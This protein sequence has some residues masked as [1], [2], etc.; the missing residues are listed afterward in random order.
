M[1]IDVLPFTKGL[2]T[3]SFDIKLVEKVYWGHIIST[4][5]KFKNKIFVWQN[6]AIKK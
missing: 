3:C 2:I 1:Y 4:D 6:L 5:I